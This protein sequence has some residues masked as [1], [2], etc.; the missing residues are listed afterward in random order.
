MKPPRDVGTFLSIINKMRRMRKK[1]A[2][3]FFEEIEV[4]INNISNFIKQQ[5]EKEKEMHDS[6]N[7]LILY[8]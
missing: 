3:I 4:D 2:N 6:F 8:K 7:D 5:S 1:A